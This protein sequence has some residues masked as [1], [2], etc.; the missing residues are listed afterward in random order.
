MDNFDLDFLDII[1][2]LSFVIS[3]ENLQLNQQQSSIVM[4][5]LRKNQNA[6]LATIIKQ[7]EEIIEL[8]KGQHNDT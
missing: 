2:L 3:I 1:T 6:M 4:D 8:L 7:N 5:E